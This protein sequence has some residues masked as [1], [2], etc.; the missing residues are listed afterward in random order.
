MTDTGNPG[1]GGSGTVADAA[2]GNWVDRFAPDWLKPFARVARWDRPIGWWLLLLPCL[3]SATLAAD[4]EG[5]ALPN[6]WHLFLFWVGAVAMRGAG[7]TYNDIVDRNIDAAVERTAS[8]PIPSGQLS[9]LNAKIFLV[10]QALAGLLVLL[11]FNA[12]TIWL[13]IASL[14]F[15]A[16]YP[17]MKRITD[18][19]QFVL[20]L[21]FSWGALVGWTALT[22]SLDWSPILLYVGGILW[23][24]GYD[25]IYAHQ[26]KEDDAIVG[27]RSTA[28]LFGDKTRYWLILFYGAATLCFGL[29]FILA[30]A[31]LFAFA[32]LLAGLLHLAWQAIRL[33][34]DNGDDCLRL[35]KSNKTYGLIL[36][37]G[38]VAD[39]VMTAG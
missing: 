24:I 21:A 23:T 20:G 2:K 27:V 9:V 35:F 13:G 4:A 18:W 6:L 22:G 11:Q 25:T 1:A 33:D 39:T 15:V 28:L 8:R 38:L 14:G 30:D 10:A 32:G 31:R 7:C 36:L 12:Y 34:I 3:W 19:P 26:D 17:F 29:A 5:Y 37:A 16:A